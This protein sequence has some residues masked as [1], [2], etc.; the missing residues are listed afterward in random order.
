[1]VFNNVAYNLLQR[2]HDEVSQTLEVEG[3]WDLQL[4]SLKEKIRR[5]GGSKRLMDRY[6]DYR[7]MLRR[8]TPEGQILGRGL[9]GSLLGYFE[10]I[11]QQVEDLRLVMQLPEVNIL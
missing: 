5:T 2:L 6:L 1:M 9:G 4:A 3:E 8:V 7:Q 11:C 10:E